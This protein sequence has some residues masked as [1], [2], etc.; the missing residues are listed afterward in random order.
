MGPFDVGNPKFSTATSTEKPAGVGGA[1]PGVE[2]LTSLTS[3]TATKRSTAPCN[4]PPPGT[5]RMG[6][7]R[8]GIANAS[9]ESYGGSRLAPEF[10]RLPGGVEWG[11]VEWRGVAWRE[12]GWGGVAW[13]GGRA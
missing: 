6:N 8:G 13:A 11:G 1:W 2:A 9:G 7:A 5:G 10:L 12:V 3:L 4:R